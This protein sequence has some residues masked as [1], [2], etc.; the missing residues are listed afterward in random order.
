M[1]SAC[2]YGVVITHISYLLCA[3]RHITFAA[4]IQRSTSGASWYDRDVP[5]IQ[6]PLSGRTKECHIAS[7][8]YGKKI[9]ELEVCIIFRSVAIQAMANRYCVRQRQGCFWW[10]TNPTQNYH[11]VRI[12]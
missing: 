10:A 1:K 7:V 11:R 3:S 5:T 6:C 9:T 8:N 2:C 4:L 12:P